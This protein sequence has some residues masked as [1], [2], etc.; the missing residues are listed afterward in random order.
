MR[1]QSI[2]TGLAILGMCLAVT[3]PICRGRFIS[4]KLVKAVEENKVA[5]VRSLLDKGISVNTKDRHGIPLLLLSVAKGH[6]ET[7]KLLLDKGANVDIKQDIKDFS[8]NH[9][10]FKG[11]G[12]VS[13]GGATALQV[14]AMKGDEYLVQLLID[15]GADADIS[16]DIIKSNAIMQ[17]SEQAVSVVMGGTAL[18]LALAVGQLKTAKLLLPKTNNVNTVCLFSTPLH[19]AITHGQTD[20]VKA[21]LEKGAE[22]NI[23]DGWFGWTPL[24][25]AIRRPSDKLADPEIIKLLL[26]YGADPDA[27]SGSGHTPLKAAC[28][29]DCLEAAKLLLDYGADVNT[30]RKP[31]SSMLNYAVLVGNVGLVEL[32]L[33]YGIDLDDVTNRGETA[34]DMAV[35]RGCADIAE[36]LRKH[37]AKTSAE[38]K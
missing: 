37:G 22:V 6:R 24:Y 38:I 5:L 10:L 23:K 20:M 14:A 36:I 34:L 12:S 30:L 7:T 21:L 17:R 18:H 16:S 35:N 32:L 29:S 31:G 1:K 2:I 13:Y 9:P 19:Q 15:N 8:I 4:W 11:S 3:F 26:E 25:M 27:E 28:Y 33:D